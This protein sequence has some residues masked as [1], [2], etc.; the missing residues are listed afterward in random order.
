MT[1]KRRCDKSVLIVIVFAMII[2]YIYYS[3]L[4]VVISSSST[5]TTSTALSGKHDGRSS[6]DSSSSGSSTEFGKNN[7]NNKIVVDVENNDVLS[8]ITT[9]TS[10]SIK[11]DHEDNVI[12]MWKQKSCLPQQKIS[13]SNKKK[14]QQTK[15]K[16]KC[17]TYIPPEN[18][19]RQRVAIL[20]PPGIL[21]NEFMIL[22]QHA[23]DTYYK[24]PSMS[25]TTIDRIAID[26]IRTSHIA[27]YGYGKTHGYTRI[28]RI[29]PTPLI[30]GV[31]DMLHNVS[32]QSSS[33]SPESPPGTDIIITT[34]DWKSAVRQLIRYHCRLSHISAHTAL[35]SITTHEIL[36]VSASSL[37]SG[38]NKKTTELLKQFMKQIYD[39]LGLV[40]YDDDENNNDQEQLLLQEVDELFLSSLSSSINNGSNGDSSYLYSY[41]E[42]EMEKKVSRMLSRTIQYQ[43]Q[44]QQ[45]KALS[46]SSSLSTTITTVEQLLQELDTVLVNE[47]KQ[48]KNLSTWPCLSFWTVGSS[49]DNHNGNGNNG[50]NQMSPMIQYL[51]KQLSPNCDAPFTKC[52]VA[53]DVCE[54]HGDGI[55]K[56]T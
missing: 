18:Q 23:I 39:F 56:T 3:F 36:V 40:Q 17:N 1:T 42:T 12:T 20:S 34:D 44:Q 41:Y 45:E 47:L 9:T 5:T 15:D 10:S 43:Q 32:S 14:K 49:N 28:I 21:T 11:L 55:C 52:F 13:P 8:P 16:Q 35:W 22:L 51:A 38:G 25:S 26:V 31:A 30:L 2:V 6:K 24:N 4:I 37:G 33:S 27:P 54:Y 53:R 48:T 50:N 7:N 29:I 46:S 19:N